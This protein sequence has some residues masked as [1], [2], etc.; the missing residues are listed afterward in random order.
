MRVGDQPAIGFGAALL[1]G[2][3]LHQHH[4][5]GAIVDAGRIARGHRAVLPEHR[6]QLRQILGSR[7]GA[8]VLVGVEHR[9]APPRLQLDRQDLLREAALR[10]RARRAA[11]RFDR[12]RILV[13]PR[14]L[15]ALGQVLGGLAHV[16]VVERIVQRGQH[17]VDHRRIA[18]A[19]APAH[20]LRQIRRA[21]HA[22]RAAAHGDIGIAE[23]DGLRRRHDRLQ[24][25]SRT[26]G[27]A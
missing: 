25:R 18:H 10:D 19:R 3:A 12:Q 9:L 13:A 8:H 27:S 23:H 6:P 4:G 5:G 24:A 16:D 21:A 15:V 22:L 20:A 2:R 17:H 26:G 7:I 11:V 14:D 1:G